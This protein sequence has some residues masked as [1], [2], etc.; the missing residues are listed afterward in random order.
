M[1]MRRQCSSLVI[2]VECTPVKSLLPGACCASA[3][4]VRSL[5]VGVGMWP[6]VQASTLYEPF[7]VRL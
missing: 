2:M 3:L 6:H 7:C 4:V 1:S 5:E